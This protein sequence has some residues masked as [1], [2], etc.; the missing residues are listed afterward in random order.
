MRSDGRAVYISWERHHGVLNYNASAF[1][2]CR[3]IVVVFLEKQT[4]VGD[5]DT[6]DVVAL[7]RAADSCAELRYRPIYLHTLLVG[8]YVGHFKELLGMV[9]AFRTV[10]NVRQAEW[11]KQKT[12]RR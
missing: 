4:V 12:L 1:W 5:A 8:R 3:R 6:R 7:C 9:E 11:S 10:T 2:H